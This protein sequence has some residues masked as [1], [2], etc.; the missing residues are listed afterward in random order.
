LS[1]L[2]AK[3]TNNFHANLMLDADKSLLAGFKAGIGSLDFA[4]TIDQEGAAMALSY[5]FIF[6]LRF[7]AKDKLHTHAFFQFLI[8][9][10]LPS[11]ACSC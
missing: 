1:I 5:F 4:Q 6:S 10:H 8:V 3:I 11:S 2:V 9:S 7:A